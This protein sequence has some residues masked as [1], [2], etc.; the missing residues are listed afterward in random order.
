[1]EEIALFNYSKSFFLKFAY[2]QELKN[3]DDN[4]H[5]K[6][7]TQDTVNKRQSERDYNHIVKGNLHE[8]FQTNI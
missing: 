5:K 6:Q 8:K 3:K 1:M 2:L 7:R 4:I